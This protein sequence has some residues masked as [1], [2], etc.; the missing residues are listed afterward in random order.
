MFNITQ[1][2][3]RVTSPHSPSAM[4]AS[5]TITHDHGRANLPVRVPHLMPFHIQHTGPAPVSTYFRIRPHA[6]P[7]T[8]DPSLLSGDSQTKF[9]TATINTKVVMYEEKENLS[10][11]A[12]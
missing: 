6:G 9:T 5:I 10:A 7:S 2:T 8:P 12:D 4:A 1:V 11:T 3:Q